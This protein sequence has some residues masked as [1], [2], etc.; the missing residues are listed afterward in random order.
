MSIRD[1]LRSFRRIEPAT[2]AI[3]KAQLRTAR[4]QYAV[5]VQ[6]RDLV[7]LDAVDDEASAARWQ[8]LDDS[9]QE[10][11][12]R[13]DMLAAALP[14]A[15]AREDEA[16][17]QADEQKRQQRMAAYLERTAEAQR[18]LDAVLERLPDGETLTAA[19]DRR[20][21]L[22][23]DARELSTCSRDVAVRRPLDPLA[24]I[25]NE[26]ELRVARISRARWIGEHPITLGDKRAS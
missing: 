3:I 19:R 18:W 20:D 22:Y 1:W 11:A 7:A 12:S 15:L 14:M 8:H 13:I 9:T 2:A 16:R 21:L 10:L 23:A 6:Q 26:L 25:N 24:V 17:E 4:D 5:A